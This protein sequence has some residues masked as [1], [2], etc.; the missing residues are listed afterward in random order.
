ML[1]IVIRPCAL[2]PTLVPLEDHII[3]VQLFLSISL[4]LTS[5]P[6]W[7]AETLHPKRRVKG[8][9][10]EERLSTDGRFHNVQLYFAIAWLDAD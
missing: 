9:C 3:S 1:E 7:P 5:L 4:Q 6:S 10:Q 2:S 8:K